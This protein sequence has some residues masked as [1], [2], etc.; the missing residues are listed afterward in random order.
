MC[1]MFNELP[2]EGKGRQRVG[3]TGVS[4]FGLE[5]SGPAE[6]GAGSLLCPTAGAVA[7]S[8]LTPVNIPPSDTASGNGIATCCP[9]RKA[10]FLAGCV[11]LSFCP[12]C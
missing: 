4:V 5:C 12:L 8:S 9:Q 10:S 2:K 7:M 3:A 6:E 11:S 1:P